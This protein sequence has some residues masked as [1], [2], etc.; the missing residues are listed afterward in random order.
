MVF[1]VKE[2]TYQTLLNHYIKTTLTN[3]YQ[4]VCFMQTPAYI[5]IVIY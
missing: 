1:R 5:V 3:K 2:T 4:N